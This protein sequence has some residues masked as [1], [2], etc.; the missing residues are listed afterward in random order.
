[1]SNGELTGNALRNTVHDDCKSDFEPWK[2]GNHSIRWVDEQL[3]SVCDPMRR[4][5]GYLSKSFD[6]G[7][8]RF[9]HSPTKR[10]ISFT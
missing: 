5:Q 6:S 8:L 3:C 2:A 1:M 9:L 4:L 7:G 10:F